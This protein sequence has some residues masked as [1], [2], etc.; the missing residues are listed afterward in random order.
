[1]RLGI[2]TSSKTIVTVVDDFDKISV[3]KEKIYAQL[4]I[5]P[6][7]VEK[8]SLFYAGKDLEDSR[9]IF[10]YRV[11]DYST[12]DMRLKLKEKS[13]FQRLF[14]HTNN[15]QAEQITQQAVSPADVII[16]AAAAPEPAADAPKNYQPSEEVDSDEDPA[17][18]GTNSNQRRGKQIR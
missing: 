6:R 2:K 18:P 10:D 8:C 13:L 17:D 14:S 3:I 11:E 7:D 15:P 9:A 12:L 4:K 1:M 5:N 16:P